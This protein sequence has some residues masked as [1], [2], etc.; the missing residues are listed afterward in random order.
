MACQLQLPEVGGQSGSCCV[1]CL[2]LM[3]L[4]NLLP[5]ADSGI[6]I[7]SKRQ[8]YANVYLLNRLSLQYNRKTPCNTMQTADCQSFRRSLHSYLPRTCHPYAAGRSNPAIWAVARS[9]LPE[10]K[11]WATQ[12]LKQKFEVK[13]SSLNTRELGCAE[14]NESLK[15]QRF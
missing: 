5:S 3:T 8:A 10:D 9:L 2:C 13:V 11:R 6:V 4:M 1:V 15:R 12:F 14:L 7:W